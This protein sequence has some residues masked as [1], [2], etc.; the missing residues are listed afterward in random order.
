MY[1]A[2]REI[3]CKYIS[4]WQSITD[5]YL[6]G[7]TIITQECQTLCPYKFLLQFKQYH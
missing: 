3:Q 5:V 2:N 1:R 6:F 7:E 4:M